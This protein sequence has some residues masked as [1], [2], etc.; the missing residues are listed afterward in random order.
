MGLGKTIQMIAFLAGL[1]FSKKLKGPILIVCPATILKQWVKGTPSLILE[2]HK[3][4]PPFRVAILHASGFGINAKGGM[5]YD[6]D[7]ADYDK[8]KQ[9]KQ[10]KSKKRNQYSSD[11]PDFFSDEEVPKIRKKSR[12]VK[13]TKNTNSIDELINHIAQNGHVL[14]TT[15]AAIR[16]YSESLIPVNWDYC[17]LDEGH[18]IRNPDSQVTLA[19]KKLKVT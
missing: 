7:S 1:G 15:Y 14:V 13:Q 3:W 11:S 8:P 5:D 12:F 19:C 6:Y 17:V 10:K 9:K 18:K 2:F 4:W 16:L